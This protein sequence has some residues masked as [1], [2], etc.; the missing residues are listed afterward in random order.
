MIR[1]YF[2]PRIERNFPLMWLVSLGCAPW[3]LAPLVFGRAGV[4]WAIAFILYHITGVGFITL[5]C[6][7]FLKD[8]PA[9]RVAFAPGTGVIVESGLF[10]LA[11]H[12][13][14]NSSLLYWCTCAVGWIGAI[15]LI[16]SMLQVS[17]ATLDCRLLRYLILVSIIVCLSYYVTNIR[18]NHVS[19][20]EQGYSFLHMDSTFNMTIAAAIKNGVKL[21]LPTMGEI[22]LVYHYGS[23]SIAANYSHF[24]GANLSDGLVAL[25]GI[26]LMA[27]LSASV[28]LASIVSQIYGGSSILGPVAGGLGVIFLNN[29]TEVMRIS[30]RFIVKMVGF[31]SSD[32][33]DLTF[34]TGSTNHFHTGQSTLW[35]S[36]GLIVILG[37]ALWYW[38][39]KG[40]LSWRRESILPF[41]TTLVCPLN[42][43]AGIAAS[44][45][46]ATV[47]LIKDIRSWKSFG[48]AAALL[49]TTIGIL[50]IMGVIG[51]QPSS[52]HSVFAL[53]SNP[54]GKIFVLAT[55][56]AASLFWIFLGFGVGL[57]PLGFLF[58]QPM[59]PLALMVL[60]LAIGGFMFS[61][62]I[63][64][65]YSNDRY[66]L[67]FFYH[68]SVVCSMAILSGAFWKWSKG[69]G[70]AD[71]VDYTIGMWAVITLVS[72]IFL[73]F[74]LS[75]WVISMDGSHPFHD[76][77][78]RIFAPMLTASLGCWLWRNVRKSVTARSV[79][80]TILICVIL[81]QFGGS[82][83]SI[84]TYAKMPTVNNNPLLVLD[85]KELEGLIRLRSV[86]EPNDLC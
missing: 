39:T 81:A 13:C 46:L 41:L 51:M 29:A 30:F 37:L 48:S 68:F 49:S 71:F 64:M 16:R 62:F 15:L 84:Y 5:L 21:W 1:N 47:G 73:V 24:T 86:S 83:R 60:V 19:T 43:F 52:D 80:L 2:L 11:V 6:F 72:F 35:G 38:G 4:T 3:L 54:W 18:K 9:L 32:I 20:A 82:I 8:R 7:D 42:V 78:V 61:T 85:A 10:Y 63:D 56:R 75:V 44:G 74:Q 31:S 25:A 79:S 65:D 66:F 57:V 50:W 40:G 70:T 33:P 67:R 27:L 28:G 12:F 36:L 17:K 53:L 69:K 26:G 59:R 34:G 58:I 55:D 22:P 77:I 76:G 14:F 45:T 23:Q